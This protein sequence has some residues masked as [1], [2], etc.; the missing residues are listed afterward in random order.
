[1]KAF[2]TFIRKCDQ[3]IHMLGIKNPNNV[4]FLE[5]INLISGQ[6]IVSVLE[7][8]VIIGLYLIKINGEIFQVKG[9]IDFLFNLKEIND[10]S[11]L[12]VKKYNAIRYYLINT[13]YNLSIKEFGLYESQ[14]DSIEDSIFYNYLHTDFEISQLKTILNR[15]INRSDLSY[16]IK[17]RLIVQL[18]HVKPPSK[19][20][21]R[22]KIDIDLSG[23]SIY[24]NTFIQ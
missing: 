17:K 3:D 4:S 23:Y 16:Y 19:K 20:I 14:L 18:R 15:E 1:M 7:N 5:E 2:L 13:F 9:N 12:N 10:I 6:P 21:L 11:T 22:K 24:I 8:D